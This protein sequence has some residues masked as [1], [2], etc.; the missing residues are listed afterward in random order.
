MNQGG[1]FSLQQSHYNYSALS[2]Q[3]VP[4]GAVPSTN[5]MSIYFTSGSL[6]VI[7]HLHVEIVQHYS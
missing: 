3:E 6:G 5:N 4:Y 7:Q 1:T 2:F